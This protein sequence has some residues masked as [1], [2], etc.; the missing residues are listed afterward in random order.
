M[1]VPFVARLVT[2]VLVVGVLGGCSGSD[3]PEPETDPTE[4]SASEGAPADVDAFCAS[5]QELNKEG[6]DSISAEQGGEEIASLV[7]N[8]PEEVAADVEVLSSSYQA[9]V[10]AIQ[11]AGYDISVLNDGT[12]LTAEEQ[13]AIRADAEANGYDVEASDAAAKNVEA[14][15]ETNCEG[16]V[17]DETPSAQAPAGDVEA[18]CGAYRQITGD[19]T[20]KESLKQFRVLVLNAPPEVS[21]AAVTLQSGIVAYAD[22]VKAAGFD[23]SVLDDQSKLSTKEQ[24]DYNAAIKAANVDFEAAEAAA[25]NL[26]TWVA[27]NC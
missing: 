13:A 24:A 3:D 22:A 26:N 9:L 21:A 8:A 14:W 1:K 23:I 19:I 15:A 25:N 12:Q 5:F 2:A 18:V 20:A 27:A 7:E 4:S 17:P 16:Y 11:A 10:D 6:E